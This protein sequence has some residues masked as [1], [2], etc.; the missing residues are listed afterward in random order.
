MPVNDETKFKNPITNLPLVG[1][2]V[3]LIIV[4]LIAVQVQVG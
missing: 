2:A 1:K 4:I 3:F